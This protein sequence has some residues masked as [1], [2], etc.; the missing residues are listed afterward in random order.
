MPRRTFLWE[1]GP[2]CKATQVSQKYLHNYP[3]CTTARAS[4][5]L[6]I[7]LI[8]SLMAA[9]FTHWFPRSFTPLSLHHQGDITVKVRDISKKG[10]K[11][12]PVNSTTGSY[13]TSA[14]VVLFTSK[15]PSFQNRNFLTPYP[16]QHAPLEPSLSALAEPHQHISQK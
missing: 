1:E 3:G 15:L 7:K 2:I 4:L 6:Y 13:K 8:P 9:P 16:K 11:A 10:E 14:K 5:E 12:Q